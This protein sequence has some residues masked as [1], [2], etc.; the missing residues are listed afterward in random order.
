MRWVLVVAC[1]TPSRVRFLVN[2]F[3]PANTIGWQ[4]RVTTKRTTGDQKDVVG[5]VFQR[6]VGQRTTDG[7]NEPRVRKRVRV[8]GLCVAIAAL[9]IAVAVVRVR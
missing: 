6:L 4:N 3:M 7:R 2:I 5:L 9:V 8:L 1:P